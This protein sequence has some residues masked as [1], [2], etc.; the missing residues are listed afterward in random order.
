M[1]GLGRRS[2]RVGA[3]RQCRARTGG[4]P[5]KMDPWFPVGKAPSGTFSG[6]AAFPLSCGGLQSRSRSEQEGQE[7]L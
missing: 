2:W 5:F 7:T 1:V 6:A 3:R 4:D